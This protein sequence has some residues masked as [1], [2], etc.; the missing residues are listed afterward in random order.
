M[1]SLGGRLFVVSVAVLIMAATVSVAMLGQPAPQTLAQ[2]SFPRR[3][4]LA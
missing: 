3:E 4:P 1:H 2:S